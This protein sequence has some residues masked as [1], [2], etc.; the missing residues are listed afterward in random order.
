MIKVK[1]CPVCKIGKPRMIFYALPLATNPQVWEETEDCLCEPMVTYKKVECSNCGAIS[2]GYQIDLN[3]A[4][5]DWNYENEE[6]DRTQI[7]QYIIEESLEV[8][9]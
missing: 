5:K 9:E 4:V 7:L 8:E 2:I 3:E 6:G 1:P